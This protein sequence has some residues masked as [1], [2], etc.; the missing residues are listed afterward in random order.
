MI[1]T[2]IDFPVFEA[3]QVLTNEHLN[4]IRIYLDEQN[5]LSR[6]SLH[7]IGIVCGLDVRA[8]ST[9]SSVIIG[10]G[11]GVTSEGYIAIVGNEDFVADRYQDYVVPKEDGYALLLKIQS[12]TAPLLELLDSG[13]V[14]YGIGKPVTAGV[15]NGKSVI[16]FVELLEENLKNC[17]PS[18][19]DDKGKK[20]TVNIRKLLIEKTALDALNATI[21]KNAEDAKAA[22]D[23]FPDWTARL[24]LPDLRLPRLAFDVDNNVDAQAI[25]NAYGSILTKPFF[26]AL[27]QAL[28]ESYLAFQP[29]VPELPGIH[30]LSEK[31]NAVYG[32]YQGIPG[33]KEIVFAQYF[34]DFVDDVIQ[35]YNEFRCKAYSL[36]SLCNPPEELF[37]RHLELG[38]LDGGNFAG[39]KINRHYFRPSPA[40]VDQKLLCKEVQQLFRR[41]RLILE[42]FELPESLKTGIKISLSRYG[43]AA[44]SDKAIPYYFHTTGNSP[45]LASWNFS[46]SASGRIVENTGYNIDTQYYRDFEPQANPL[47]Y[48]HENYNFYRVEGHIGLKWRDVLKD[49]L[50]QI[51]LYRLPFDVVAL[52]AHPA[53]ADSD[54]TACACF[55]NDLQVIYDAWS[56]ELECLLKQDVKVITGF[57]IPVKPVAAEVSAA[58]PARA[59]SA[60]PAAA[61]IA[62]QIDAPLASRVQ[63]RSAARINILPGMTVSDGSLGKILVDAISSQPSLP[64]IK[65]DISGRVQ[66]ILKENDEINQLSVAD[67]SVGIGKPVELVNAL[68]GFVDALP[69]KAG[70]LDYVTVSKAYQKYTGLIVDY[71]DDLVKYSPPAENPVITAGQKEEILNALNNFSHECLMARLEE[72]GA[73]LERRKKQIEELAFFN[74]FIRKHPGLEHKA[75][76]PKGGTFVLVY[77]ETPTEINVDDNGSFLTHKLTGELKSEATAKASPSALAS[78]TVSKL[79]A[80]KRRILVDA[81]RGQGI[82]LPLEVLANLGQINPP[83]HLEFGFEIPELVVIADF[84]LPYRFSSDCPPVQ[85]VLPPPRPLFVL[86]PECQGTDGTSLVRFEISRGTPP[87]EVQIDDEPYGLLTQN[88]IKLEVGTHKV[89]LRDAEGGISLPQSIDI[90]RRFSIELPPKLICDETNT[91]YTAIVTI[92][93]G[94]LPF[95]VYDQNGENGQELEATQVGDD[96]NKHTVSV[97][98]FNSGETV[99]IQIGDSSMICPPQALVF[100]HTCIPLQTQ[101]D[102][103]VTDYNTPVTIDVLANDSGNDLEI[104]SATVDATKGEVVVNEGRSITFKPN[105]TVQNED[106]AITY[107]VTDGN[108][109]TM[110]STATVHVNKKPCGL[111]CEGLTLRRGYAFTLP[112]LFIEGLEAKFLL[113]FPQGTMND[114]SAELL[115][116]WQTSDGSVFFFAQQLNELIRKLTGS[117][118]WLTIDPNPRPPEFGNLFNDCS[119]EYYQCLH[120]ELTFKFVS[121]TNFANNIVSLVPESSHLEID[122]LDAST[123]NLTIPAYNPVRID[124]C[125]PGLPII[126]V[127]ASNAPDLTLD[128]NLEFI[129]AAENSITL[130]LSALPTGADLPVAYLWEVESGHPFIMHGE[131]NTVTFFNVEPP[132]KHVRLAAFTEKGCRVVLDKT[133]DINIG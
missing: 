1:P 125:N 2:K 65:P 25:F 68:N 88:S 27:G 131:K 67:Y 87:F 51:R 77:Q 107:T 13:H 114:L 85:F 26:D 4:N 31:L 78:P 92:V 128:I 58:K 84:F 113:E 124:K 116:L 56:K 66:A 96:I 54:S 129:S 79:T 16:I 110:S 106:V 69:D 121:Q 15:L 12:E 90:F 34:Y 104:T 40:L 86:K 81:L 49:L 122:S 23:F 11:Y 120:F 75:G 70:D 18:S 71:R 102:T 111:P 48:D 30:Y 72:L 9:G 109:K 53:T 42:N 99:N 45:L 101:P 41:L 91:T 3:N 57:K 61:K 43:N 63:L 132:S 36:I 46:K 95:R 97:G 133:V 50:E 10:K 17:S 44:L 33:K 5:R 82:T 60:G 83:T 59:V 108:D 20:V 24:N 38:E 7:G 126:D 8:T 127:C 105:E 123:T 80:E 32:Q 76:V 100:T 117:E 37:P 28:D 103:A 14:D 89:V 35:A 118:N 112:P 73:E 62:G 21:K 98:P 19:C 39:Y 64:G 47:R 52:N 55:S 22:G 74:K 130:A 29:I 6:V 119:I 93:D 94:K 115:N